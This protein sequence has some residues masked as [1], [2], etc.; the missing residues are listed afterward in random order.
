MV[1]LMFFLILI[2]LSVVFYYFSVKSRKKYT[3][4]K[5]GEE[6]TTEHLDAKHCNV[7]GAEIKMDE[8]NK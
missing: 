8:L 7:C 6:I 2:V 1:E 5:C 4:P 3:C